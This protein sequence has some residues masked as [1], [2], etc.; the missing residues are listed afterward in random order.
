MTAKKMSRLVIIVVLFVILASCNKGDN[1]D[2]RALYGVWVKGSNYG[3]TLWFTEKNG[4]HIMQQT[5]IMNALPVKTEKEFQFHKGKLSI[6]VFAP[7]SSE[8]RT[9][10][11]FTWINRGNDFRILGIELFMYMSSSNTYFAYHKID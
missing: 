10:N 4:R 11:S 1:D 8:F 6:Q 7:A 5:E 9:I 2:A 3:D